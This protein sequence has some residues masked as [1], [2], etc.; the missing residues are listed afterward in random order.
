MYFNCSRICEHRSFL[1]GASKL[2][3]ENKDLMN[4]TEEMDREEKIRQDISAKIADAAAEVQDEIDEASA[5]VEEEATET[6]DGV[7]MTEDASWDDA[8]FV[9][10][11]KEP[12]KVTI[13]LSNLVLSLIGTA[14]IGALILLG[15]QQIPGIISAMPEGS[16]AVTVDGEKVT[17]VDMQYYIYKAAAEYLNSAEDAKN[18]KSVSEYDWDKEVEDGKTA[19]DIVKERAVEAAVADAV[20][21][22]IGDKNKVDFDEKAIRDMYN[23][24]ND[25]LVKQFGDELVDLNAKAQGF[26]SVKHNVRHAVKTENIAAVN[27]D[28]EEN[29]DKYYPEDKSALNDYATDTKATVK[30]IL[31]STQAAAGEEGAEAAPAEDKKAL[32]EEVLARAKSG[33]DF[34]ALVAEFGEDP[35]AT[36]EGYTFGPGE[37][38]PEFEEAAFA[39]GID[40]ISEIVET[41]Y[42]YHIIK[43]Y[44]GQGELEGYLKSQAKVKVNEKAIEKLSV[45]DI[46]TEVDQ[47]GEDFQKMYSE[48]Q[49]NNK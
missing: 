3:N 39:L 20:L 36:E 43:R 30:H 45:K 42:G 46:L 44:A 32:A 47:A 13:T 4:G 34:D 12:K 18:T 27:A 5:S 22:S 29:A 6:V 8:S 24:Q 17:D 11:V 10:P 48:F 33:E 38:M 9:E 14:V 37:M 41:S 16:T 40:E 23:V 2:D 15:A 25:Q 49:S 26:T 19:G 1:K 7:E 35:G 28:I 21:V 31:I